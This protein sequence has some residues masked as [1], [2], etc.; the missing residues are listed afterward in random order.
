MPKNSRKES[1][2]EGPKL[3]IEED[4]EANERGT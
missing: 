1:E 2:A 4:L 3:K